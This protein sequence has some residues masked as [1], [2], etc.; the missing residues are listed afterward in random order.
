MF[1]IVYAFL[2]P[3]ILFSL[4]FLVVCLG[5]YYLL[6]RA[7]LRELRDVG[8]GATG[9]DRD[10]KREN[11]IKAYRAT[12]SIIILRIIKPCLPILQSQAV[13]LFIYFGLRL[14]FMMFGVFPK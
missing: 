12:E 4:I 3:C 2:A 7:S 11:L 6:N 9:L 1:H 14:I 13:H 5:K 8:S 10:C